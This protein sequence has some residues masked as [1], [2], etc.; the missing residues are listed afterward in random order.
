MPFAPTY[1]SDPTHFS[2]SSNEKSA[3]ARVSTCTFLGRAL[4]HLAFADKWLKNKPAHRVSVCAKSLLRSKGDAKSDTR[5]VTRCKLFFGRQNAAS[6]LRVSC[7]HVRT[8]KYPPNATWRRQNRATRFC[9]NMRKLPHEPHVCHFSV[10][11]EIR[12]SGLAACTLKVGHKRAHYA[13]AVA[14]LG[15]GLAC[16]IKRARQNCF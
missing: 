14:F 7:A 15:F 2:F 12:A 10:G 8:H 1:L 4:P 3:L 16:A 9:P 13:R 6:T 5:M 11:G